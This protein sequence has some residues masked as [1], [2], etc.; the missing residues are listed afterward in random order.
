MPEQPSPSHNHEFD[1]D[2]WEVLREN[3]TQTMLYE[4]GFGKPLNETYDETYGPQD[5]G[6]KWEEYPLSDAKN[7]DREVRRAERDLA[8]EALMRGLLTGKHE[9]SEGIK[10]SELE[11]RPNRDDID[12]S[13]RV[14]VRRDSEMIEP[15][16]GDQ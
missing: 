11:N 15:D 6:W 4:T 16:G 12:P 7:A 5:E 14:L 10:G 9:T 2:D 8:H 1:N 13:G 3:V